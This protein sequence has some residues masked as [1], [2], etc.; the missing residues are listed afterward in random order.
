M[1]SRFRGN[2]K[3]SQPRRQPVHRDQVFDLNA[4]PHH[5]VLVVLD[6]HFRHQRAASTDIKKEKGRST[7]SVSKFVCDIENW[8]LNEIAFLSATQR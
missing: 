6:Q 4:G 3:Y 7:S 1:G 5:R 8:T 2:D